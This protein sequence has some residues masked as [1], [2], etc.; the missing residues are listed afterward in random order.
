MNYN[1]YLFVFSK[2]IEKTDIIRAE[3]I[4]LIEQ[5][6]KDVVIHID[7]ID[8]IKS[9]FKE[10]SFDKLIKIQDDNLTHIIFQP[11]SAIVICN[12]KIDLEE[13]IRRA[14]Y[15]HSCGKF[16]FLTKWENIS[17][18]YIE[19]TVVN[20]CK[21]ENKWYKTVFYKESENKIRN[22]LPSLLIDDKRYHIKND[23]FNFAETKLKNNLKQQKEKLNLPNEDGY[24]FIFLE[25][26]KIKSDMLLSN[27][28][29]D[30]DLIDYG[31]CY[32]SEF[33]KENPIHE[34]DDLKEIKPFWAGI[35]TTPHRLM[36][37]MLNL[38]KVNKN[39]II[40]DP[41]SHTGT[42]AIEASNIGCKVIASD[43]MGTKGAQDNYNF[44]CSGSNNFN[45]LVKQ[46]IQHANNKV[47]TNRLQDLLNDNIKINSQGLPE[48]NGDIS[49]KIDILSERLYFYIIRRYA[50]ELKRGAD[51][52]DIN[53]FL[54]NY[55]GKS[56]NG[57]IIPGYILFGKQFKFFEQEYSKTNSPIVKINSKNEKYFIDSYYKSK[58][59]GYINIEKNNYPTFQ[60]NNICNI[61][62][63]YNIEE[64]SI[65]AVITDPPYGYGEGLNADKVKEIYSML[66]KKSIKWLKPNGYMVF[67]ALDK[68]KTGRT[69]NL[70][71]TENI[72]DI[73]VKF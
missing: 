27:L 6:K 4:S 28:Y 63:N 8:K 68:V 52:K 38:A 60:K 20:F 25:R 56:D 34:M 32:L 54:N 62:D 29:E 24:I 12:F 64:S 55:I 45:F 35:F 58:R 10:I 70:L 37:A 31:I 2:N 1:S 44:L 40:L 22:K 47:L 66:I 30:R 11:Q 50:M 7:S 67:C 49:E 39:S 33:K 36:N 9:I 15:I 48:T 53:S 13:I 72:L 21:K 42:L 71:F 65:D 16:L 61:S 46:I 59:V 18:E 69:E 41:F 51:V 5:K 23:S 57:K 14:G 26:N 3:L 43:I 17:I 19:K 73:M